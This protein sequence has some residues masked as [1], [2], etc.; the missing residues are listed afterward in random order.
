MKRAL[1]ISGGGSKGAFAVGVIRYLSVH[2]PALT[3]DI[4]VGTSTGALLAPLASAGEISILV[5]LYTTIHTSDII[6]KGNVVTRLLASNSLYDASP[7]AKL[8]TR[9]YSDALCSQLL[10]SQKEIYLVTTCLQTSKIVYFSNRAASFPTANEI[11]RLSGADEMRRAIIASACE[12][13]FMPPIEVRKGSMPLRQYVDGGVRELAGVQLAID[14]GA[15][16]IYT[17]LLTPDNK[18]AQ[19][20]SFSD[21]F[22]IL[23]KTIDIFTEEVGAND[24]S[25]P[26]AYN[27]ALRYIAAVK[28]RMLAAG[29]PAKT[30]EDY[31]NVPGNPFS[32]KKPL[33]IYLIRPD[34]PLGGGPG[35]LIFDP[36][37]MKGMLAKGEM[38]V[39][40][41]MA[42]LPPGGDMTV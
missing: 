38:K 10:Q 2:F 37:E 39:A 7:L 1:V 24:I 16:E 12:P 31:F 5:N 19:E 33:S 40:S 21:S 3:F 36:E 18:P 32:G 27:Q 9:S 28:S 34:G 26:L 35:G 30:A 13:V 15:E 11:I 20:K 22:T 8:I 6:A 14:A 42:H 41:Y 29:V 25:S 23:E 17:I 4:F